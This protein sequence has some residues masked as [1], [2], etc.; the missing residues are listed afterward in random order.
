MEKLLKKIIVFGIKKIVT[1]A[2]AFINYNHL[3]ISK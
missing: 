2:Q 3:K 1:F